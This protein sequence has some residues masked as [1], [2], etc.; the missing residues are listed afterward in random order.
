MFIGHF[1]VAFAAK[2]AAPRVSL[3]TLFAATSLADLLWPVFVAIGLE[4]VRIDPGNTAV[5]PLDFVSYPWSH[6]LLLLVL[7]A[8]L[9][10]LVHRL[11]MRRNGAAILLAFVVVSHW[12]LDY[13]THRPDMPLYPGGPKYG[14]GLWN[15]VP[16]TMIVECAMFAGAVW[17]Y[18]RATRPDDWQGRWALGSLLLILLAAYGG[19]LFGPPPPSV[20]ALTVVALIGGLLSIVW[21]AW[22]DRHRRVTR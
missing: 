3:G 18:L 22:A 5:T 4:Q 12:L 7:W 17:L 9:F 14:L 20:Q 16:A 13:V 19:N 15:S 1:A 8:C 10:A 11:L 6:S 2:R 21:A